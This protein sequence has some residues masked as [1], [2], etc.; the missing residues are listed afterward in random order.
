[1]AN[2]KKAISGVLGYSIEDNDVK[3][4]VLC[5]SRV[6]KFPV[7]TISISYYFMKCN[8]YYFMKFILENIA[9]FA[10]LFPHSCRTAI[11]IS[12]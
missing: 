9:R 2:F 6:D 10:A 1:M 7:F 3:T 4:E 11:V 8:G 5:F 12:Q